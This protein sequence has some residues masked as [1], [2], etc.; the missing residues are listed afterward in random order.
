MFKPYLAITAKEGIGTVKLSD[1]D[2]IFEIH[3]TMPIPA[4]M[5]FKLGKVRQ[6][7][8]DK[9]VYQFDTEAPL[10]LSRMD[11]LDKQ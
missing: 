11:F 4:E 7:A 8:P 9:I 6:P 5:R 2:L 1:A 10:D 3:P